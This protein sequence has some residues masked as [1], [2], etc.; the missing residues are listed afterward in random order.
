MV[1][2]LKPSPGANPAPFTHWMRAPV[3]LRMDRDSEVVQAVAVSKVKKMVMRHFDKAYLKVIRGHNLY[4]RFTIPTGREW[5]DGLLKMMKADKRR[6][7]KWLSD[8]PTAIG[9]WL[10]K[11]I[12]SPYVGIEI[13]VSALVDDSLP[14]EKDMNEKELRIIYGEVK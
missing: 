14:P 3:V 11:R 5:M 12:E 9:S 2:S 8:R 4:M 7:H 10:A 6:K 13:S 1:K